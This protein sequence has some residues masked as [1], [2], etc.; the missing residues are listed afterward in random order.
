MKKLANF[1][2]ITLIAVAIVLAIC[3]A[4]FFFVEKNE[5]VG[6]IF[7]A[8]VF[9]CFIALPLLLCVNK[10][11][12]I[13]VCLVFSAAITLLC[14]FAFLR[15]YSVTASYEKADLGDVFVKVVG[16]VERV[17]YMSSGKSMV[18][19]DVTVSGRLNGKT[20]YKIFANYYGDGVDVGSVIEFSAVL[21][22]KGLKYENRFSAS[23][24]NSGIKYFASLSQEDVTLKNSA[25]TVFEKVNVAVRDVLRLNLSEGEFAVSYALLCGNSDYS[26]ANYLANYRNAGVAHVFAVSGL[27]IGFLAVVL[28][29]IFSKLKLNSYAAA[30]ITFA[31]LLFYSGVCGF[32]ASSV[33]AT[34]MCV[35]ALIVKAYGGRYD[36]L[37]SLSV[38]AIILLSIFPVQLFCAGFILSFSV[39]LGIITLSKPISRV[40]S[41]LP[42]FLA[43]SIGTVLAAEL[44]SAPVLLIFFGEFSV[45]AVLA[46]LVFIPLVGVIYVFLL[47]SV[48]LSLIISPVVFMFLPKYVLIGVNAVINA[49]DYKAFIVG[50]ITVTAIVIFYYAALIILSGLLNITRALKTVFCT[51][52]VLVFAAGTTYFSVKETFSVKA[53]AIGS[54]YSSVTVIESK[55]SRAVFV[56]SAQKGFGVS[57]IER[58]IEKRGEKPTSLIVPVGVDANLVATRL[59]ALCLINSAYYYETEENETALENSFKSIDFVSVSNSDIPFGDFTVRFC[60]KGRAIDVLAK[61]K[62]ARIFAAISGAADFEGEGSFDFIVAEDYVD[63]INFIYPCKTF[64]S[65]R[66]SAVYLNAERSGNFTYKFG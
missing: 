9:S 62:T 35:V 63:R 21:Q 44:F 34:I 59:S 60:E 3:S 51:A 32:T 39:V 16:R 45:F 48:L 26:D 41:F 40:F 33:R 12:K 65:Y 47:I 52:F 14:S 64:V 37:T 66:N 20:D 6:A 58:L 53:Y 55:S 4:Y 2:P 61:G 38:A 29:F 24:V 23:D 30:I 19:G 43:L 50:G 11:E 36:G 42:D 17:E 1:R 28:G 25:L 27:H 10:K 5:T 13:K 7:A 22:D 8:V 56:S 15:F 57:R 31:A 18:I 54:F 46:N 49:L